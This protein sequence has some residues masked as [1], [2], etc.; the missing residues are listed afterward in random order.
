MGGSGEGQEGV[1]EVTVEKPDRPWKNDKQEAPFGC[2]A[3][4]LKGQSP[5]GKDGEIRKTWTRN[6]LAFM[7][8]FSPGEKWEQQAEI[9]APAINLWKCHSG[10]KRGRGNQKSNWFNF[11]D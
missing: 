2:S 5:E 7:E 4:R 6:K 3:L 11:L 1:G 8:F 10:A 9:T